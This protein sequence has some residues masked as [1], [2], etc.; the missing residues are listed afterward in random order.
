M[1][2]TKQRELPFLWLLIALP[3]LLFSNGLHMAAIA[4]WIAPIFMLRFLRSCKAWLGLLIG[5]VVNAV[6]F[7]F[8]WHVAFKDAGEMFTLYTAAIGLLVYI[9][10]VLDR[11]V[12]HHIKGFV[13]TLVFPVAW[14]TVEYLLSISLPLGT[15]FN[16][17]Y[18]QN[19]NLPFL[20]V[21]SITGLWGISF[22]VIWFTSIV[23]YIWE[24]GFDL[25]MVGKGSAVYALI[26][27]AVLFGGGLRLAY[28]RPTGPTV[29]VSVLTTNIDGEPLPDAATPEYQQL[30]DGTLTATQIDA[31]RTKMNLINED[32]FS[33]ARV[34]ADAGA[35]IITFS[36][37]NVQVFAG[38][39]DR[40]LTAAKAIA[41]E[42]GI[43]LVFP[44]EITEADITKRADP[45][46]FQVNES[47]MIT[48]EGT[49]AYT[50]V[51]HNLLIGPETEH[52][53]RGPRQ[54]FT[55][56]TP[57]GKLA[58]VIC[59]D[60]E[61]PSFMRLA[62]Q[63]GVDII[64]S[65]AIDGTPSSE[66]NP[67]HS[68]MASYRTIESGFS[69]GR[70]G[71]YGQNVAVDY[72]GHTLGSVNHYTAG[73]R[74]VTAKIPISGVKTIYGILGDYLPWFSIATLLAF[75]TIAIIDGR[76][77]RRRLVVDAGDKITI[78][79]SE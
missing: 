61:Y 74:T 40:V 45:V 32:L 25:K 51:K 60:M 66:G 65:G 52:T 48:P 11:L 58:S 68:M 64:L 27:V 26:L 7:Y 3:F 47:V 9:P 50:Y 73:D 42:K 69:L 56:D 29:Q 67:L 30:V 62:E 44:F 57:Y 78:A 2:Q 20:Q 16:Y 34:Q 38:D 8:Q 63:Q 5:Y 22:L 31:I 10:Y 6:V 46:I 76:S 36:E 43:Y 13:S 55:I 70:A 33:R 72:L 41:V 17:A 1:E 53:V 12:T 75:I 18:T 77:S 14:V 37:F 59:L 23:V 54:I 71:Y 39:E 21:M 79:D 28:S 35:K 19:T 15:F 49:I 24:S 4:A